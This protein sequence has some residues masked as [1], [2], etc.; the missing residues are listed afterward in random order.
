MRAMPHLLLRW[1]ALVF[2]TSLQHGNAN[3]SAFHQSFCLSV[4]QRT[5]CAFGGTAGVRS[6][7]KRRLY[8]A[9]TAKQSLQTAR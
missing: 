1:M 5:S 3:D 2:A 4:Y 9:G 6:P 7:D 8:R